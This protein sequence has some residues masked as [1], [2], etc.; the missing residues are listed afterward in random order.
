MI[1]FYD[2]LVSFIMF[3]HYISYVLVYDFYDYDL[4]CHSSYIHYVSVYDFYYEYI[5]FIHCIHMF[6]FMILL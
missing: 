1:F 5:S 3:I 4:L 2:S 6:N